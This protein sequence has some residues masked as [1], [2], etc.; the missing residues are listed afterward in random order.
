MNVHT[1]PNA[2]LLDRLA[3]RLGAAYVLIADIDM[4]GHLVEARG[5]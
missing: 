2:A 3:G 1:S 4:A 5:L